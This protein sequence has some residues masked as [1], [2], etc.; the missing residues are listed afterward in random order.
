MKLNK[1]CF[2]PSLQASMQ[3]LIKQL[4]NRKVQIVGLF[5]CFLLTGACSNEMSLSKVSSVAVNRITNTELAFEDGR[6]LPL[7]FSAEDSRYLL[8]RHAEKK[9]DSNDPGLTAKGA[10][11]AAHLAEILAG[12]KVNRVYSTLTQRTIATGRPLVQSQGAKLYS[13]DAAQLDSLAIDLLT[14]GRGKTTLIVGH[15][16]TTPELAGLL[17]GRDDLP[18][19]PEIEYDRLYYIIRGT[20]GEVQLFPLRFTPPMLENTQ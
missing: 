8:V 1:H 2:F 5:A 14:T 16:N 11:R 18:K 4:S 10:Q 9:V 17:S 13:Y 19:M 12:I 15:S 3:L 6:T 20:G 7:Q